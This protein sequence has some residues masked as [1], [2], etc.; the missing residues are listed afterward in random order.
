MENVLREKTDKLLHSKKILTA[1]NEYTNLLNKMNSMEDILEETLN[2]IQNMISCERISIM[3]EEEDH[4]YIAAAK[5]VDD[6]IVKTVSVPVGKSISGKVFKEKR[7]IVVSNEMEMKD[8]S[9]NLNITDDSFMSIPM[10]ICPID[11]RDRVLGVINVT[12]K[13]DDEPFTEID[14]GILNDIAITL[15]IA[16]INKE[17]MFSLEQ[18][19][20]ALIRSMID[21]IESKD[22]HFKGHSE[23]V[24]EYCLGI[25]KELGLSPEKIEL[26]DELS[27]LHDIGKIGIPESIMNKQGKLTEDE[28]AIIKNNPLKAFEIIK[29]FSHIQ[30]G[31][32]SLRH[33]YENVNGT[34]YPDGIHSDKIEIE[35]RIISV[36]NSFDAMTTNRPYRESMSFASAIRELERCAGT[37]FD[38][39]CVKALIRYLKLKR[40]I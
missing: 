1:H 18:S 31:N 17:K 39:E 20:K 12:N 33:H 15:A 25:G 16:I 37:Q 22:P 28:Y 10:I 24:R 2:F 6:D 21:A 8:V 29:V 11:L 26:L 35:A 40:L 5:G 9:R 19:H 36:A 4:L 34:G 3:L 27:I 14:L 38:K 7:A 23:R 32:S 13:K 30:K